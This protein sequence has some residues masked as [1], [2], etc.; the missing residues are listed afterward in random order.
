MGCARA[1]VCNLSALRRR[2]TCCARTGSRC[3]RRFVASG[4]RHRRMPKACT[5][6][7]ET[8]ASPVTQHTSWAV[9]HAVCRAL[10]SSLSPA[11]QLTCSRVW[12]RSR[13]I[14]RHILAFLRTKALP[15]SPTL[16]R[17]LYVESAAYRLGS[18]RAAIERRC[19][20]CGH[21]GGWLPSPPVSRP[22][23]SVAPAQVCRTA[24]AT[25]HDRS[26]A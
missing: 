24:H 1:S 10:H 3:W 6:S 22:S 2:P 9:Q 5:S 13:W 20:L 12:P 16:L 19:V 26:D 25:A 17:E 14:F 11:Q 18:L 21:M 23:P 4:A 7:T 15:N 8:G